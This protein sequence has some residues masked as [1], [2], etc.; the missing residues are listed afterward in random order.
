MCMIVLEALQLFFYQQTSETFETKVW[1]SWKETHGD[2][3]MFFRPV[4]L[5]KPYKITQHILLKPFV[6]TN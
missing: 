3:C 2:F 4:H 5:T 6:N 1:L